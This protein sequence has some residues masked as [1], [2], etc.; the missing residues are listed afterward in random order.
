MF[1][2]AAAHPENLPGAVAALWLL[3]ERLLNGKEMIYAIA[4]RVTKCE[5]YN[6]F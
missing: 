3:L 5:E 1:F 6:E 2:R 4:S